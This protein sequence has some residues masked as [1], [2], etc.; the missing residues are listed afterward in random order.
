[1]II[2]IFGSGYV[3][4]TTGLCFS[5][6]D[7]EIQFVEID[8]K[9]IAA[10][11]AGQL[12]IFEKG[13]D[14]YLTRGVKRKTITAKAHTTHFDKPAQIYIISVGT[15]A[16]ANGKSDLKALNTVVDS[17]AETLNHDTLIIVKSTVP[18]GST[19]KIEETINK[20][21]KSRNLKLKVSVVFSPEFL[22]EG[23]ALKD[24]MNPDRII[25]G[26][27]E[28]LHEHHKSKINELFRPFNL[29]SPKMIWMSY[30]SAEL[31]KYAA[32]GMLATKISF[33]NELSKLSEKFKANI[34]DVRQGVGSDSR[35]GHDFISAGCGFGGSCFPKDLSALCQMAEEQD[36][37]SHIYRAILE[38]NKQ[39]KK[40]LGKKVKDLLGL[41]LKQKTIAIWGL[42][43]KANTDDIRDAPSLDLCEDLLKQGATL[44]LYDPMAQENYKKNFP[45]SKKVKYFKSQYEALK[46]SDCLVICTEWQEFLFPD[47][48]LIAEHIKSKTIIDGRNLYFA[49]N[50]DQYGLNYLSIGHNEQKNSNLEF[51]VAETKLP[52][53]SSKVCTENELRA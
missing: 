9:K 21:L 41:N 8:P 42:A 44:H 10:I 45:E 33:F 30:E 49:F 1:M 18:V 27:S 25:I 23:V 31:T 22:K 36:V 4:L 28:N 52:S 50:L 34:N 46:N 3:G 2:R 15:P 48:S 11:N 39:Q 6:F 16:L 26:A 7:H 35:I 53:L 32:N 40:I 19:R 12:P 38:V 47:F 14:Q 43:F 17:I 24:C 5:A 13:L 51:K 37:S 29:K 20:N